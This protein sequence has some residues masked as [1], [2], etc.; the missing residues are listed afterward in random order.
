MCAYIPFVTAA[1]LHDSSRLV[2][3]KRL[4]ADVICFV[5]APRA[6]K[7]HMLDKLTP[8]VSQFISHPY[9]SKVG[10]IDD[11]WI[12]LQCLGIIYAF[13]AGPYGS[14]MDRVCRSDVIPRLSIMQ[15]TECAVNLGLDRSIERVLAFIDKI[16]KV[17]NFKAEDVATLPSYKK[18]IFWVWLF[19][20]SH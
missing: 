14:S 12:T 3:K 9:P 4:L 20:M 16:P 19:T 11:D 5:T 18:F 7:A 13:G 1:E 6:G 2:K 10:D 15:I 8:V 17:S